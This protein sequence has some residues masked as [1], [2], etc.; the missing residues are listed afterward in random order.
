MQSIVLFADVAAGIL[1]GVQ[2]CHLQQGLVQ[3]QSADYGAAWSILF[4]LCAGEGGMSNEE[5]AKM[6]LEELQEKLPELYSMDEIRSKVDEV[7]PY[8]M[9][10]I[11]VRVCAIINADALVRAASAQSV[12]GR[13]ACNPAAPAAPPKRG[14]V[15]QQAARHAFSCSSIGSASAVA[16]LSM[17]G[18]RVP[19]PAGYRVP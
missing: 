3:Q 11:Q 14:V 1:P 10:A 5:K 4:A 13:Q 18:I 16:W 2:V 12:S 7:T 8:V 9:V 15:K 17:K 6:V 19:H